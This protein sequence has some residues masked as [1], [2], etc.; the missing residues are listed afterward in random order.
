MA[1][2]EHL[3]DHRC[4]RTDIAAKCEISKLLNGSWV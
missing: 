3:N 2:E 1:K 4:E